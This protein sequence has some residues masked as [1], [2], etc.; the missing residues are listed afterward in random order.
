MFASLA[1]QTLRDFE[2]IIVDDG[3]E[4]GALTL[5]E[6]FSNSAE[7]KIRVFV[8]NIQVSIGRGIMP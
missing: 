2:W 4:D 7:F 1:Q 8:K 5:V 3:F 6:E